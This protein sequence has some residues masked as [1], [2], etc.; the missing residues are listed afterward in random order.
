MMSSIIWYRLM[1]TRSFY[2]ESSL[3][4]NRYSSSSAILNIREHAAAIGPSIF[5]AL[6]LFH[7][8]T[9]CDATSDVY[10][11][12]SMQFEMCWKRTTCLLMSVVF[13]HHQRKIWDPQIIVCS[14]YGDSSAAKIDSL[15]VVGLMKFLC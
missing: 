1:S 11:M 7:S 10:V 9:M 12:T 5:T 6:H 14:L 3:C 8:F 15:R 4:Y 2:N 13:I